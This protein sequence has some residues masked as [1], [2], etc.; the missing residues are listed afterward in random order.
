[1][2][3][4]QL[5]AI[6]VTTN[7]LWVEHNK[8]F[9]VWNIVLSSVWVYLLEQSYPGIYFC[10]GNHFIKNHFIKALINAIFMHTYTHSYFTSDY[11]L[12]TWYYT[13]LA[14]KIH[15]YPASELFLFGGLPNLKKKRNEIHSY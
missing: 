8:L 15:F 1:M 9:F 4:H 7:C 2:C 13:Y 3:V 12:K 14:L 5:S 6:S 10:V 11:M